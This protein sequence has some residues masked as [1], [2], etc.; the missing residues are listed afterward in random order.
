MASLP[1]AIVV[2]SSDDEEDKEVVFL[3]E[4]CTSSPYRRCSSPA[5]TELFS[6]SDKEND[7]K[8]SSV[9]I[10]NSPP[11]NMDSSS[12]KINKVKLE[13]L[14]RSLYT[15]SNTTNERKMARA[16]NVM[17]QNKFK[18][19]KQR[20]K[21]L[22]AVVRIELDSMQQ[23]ES[24]EKIKKGKMVWYLSKLSNHAIFILV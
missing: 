23:E 10:M 5:K 24:P 4:V 17:L 18:I 11:K 3:E 9:V 12:F 15:N 2:L 13:N 1:S 16:S 19:D 7:S 20:L 22:R 6:S 14:K 21:Q 8:D